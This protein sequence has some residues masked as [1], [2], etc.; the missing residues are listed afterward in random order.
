MSNKI[1]DVNASI[2]KLNDFTPLNLTPAKYIASK[3]SKLQT[4][5]TDFSN[6]V[7][8]IIAKKSFNN[9]DK[10]KKNLNTLVKTDQITILYDNIDK[11]I[12]YSKVH[13]NSI[14]LDNGSSSN[15]EL[16]VE[17]I[18]ELLD[19][20]KYQI[21]T[22]IAKINNN[23]HPEEQK[24]NKKNL[25]FKIIID[26]LNLKDLQDRNDKVIKMDKRQFSTDIN[27]E[28]SILFKRRKIQNSINEEDNNNILNEEEEEELPKLKE[29]IK[30]LDDNGEKMLDSVNDLKLY[31]A[32]FH[33]DEE[34]ELHVD[35]KIENHAQFADEF[36]NSMDINIENEVELPDSNKSLVS[37]DYDYLNNN[38]DNIIY[39]DDDMI[40]IPDTISTSVDSS[41]IKKT[42]DKNY[43]ELL[44]EIPL[45]D[46]NC[47]KNIN[48]LY[49][50][51]DNISLK[52]YE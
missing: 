47:D 11:L 43:E 41:T 5:K 37:D 30:N 9:Q 40:D 13:E 36:L 19:A 42:L 35:Q 14:N 16:L 49:K 45:D 33:D 15:N 21:E 44:T 4:I 2:T 29:I 51:F 52:S 31:L 18:K 34:E 12:D 7:N 8:R 10:V 50:D 32:K 22:Y 3:L 26:K 48:D 1:T 17:E 46:E 6:K 25:K 24:I 28:N 27:K 23:N 38:K 20:Y 39:G